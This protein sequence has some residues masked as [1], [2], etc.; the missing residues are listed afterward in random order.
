[1]DLVKR[2]HSI[3]GKQK[4]HVALEAAD[5][6]EALQ[7]E[8]ES[9]K[10]SALKREK[11]AYLYRPLSRDDIRA[12]ALSS[13]F[14]F[15]IQENGEMDLNDYVFDFA[16]ALL[17]KLNIGDLVKRCKDLETKNVNLHEILSQTTG[18]IYFSEDMDCVFVDGIGNITL[19]DIELLKKANNEKKIL[20]ES[21]MGDVDQLLKLSPE[22]IDF[23]MKSTEESRLDD[24]KT[25][26]ESFHES[27][28]EDETKRMAEWALKKLDVYRNVYAK[29]GTALRLSDIVDI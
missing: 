6:I 22:G 18:E 3:S 14:K 7:S 10:L 16:D 23:L 4:G 8:V 15:R 20:I 11:A 13:G 12:I 27:D 5:R 9:L 26:L 29:E 1:M 17:S 25:W 2:L 19:G 21:M 28:H 24:F